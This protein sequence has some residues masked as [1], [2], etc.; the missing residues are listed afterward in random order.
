M[1]PLADPTQANAKNRE[2]ADRKNRRGDVNRGVAENINETNSQ[3]PLQEEGSAEEAINA[4]SSEMEET[5]E[6]MAEAI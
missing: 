3:V 1:G 4:R 2:A 5:C 6:A